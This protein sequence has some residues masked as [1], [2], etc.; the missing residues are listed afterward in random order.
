MQKNTKTYVLLALV[1]LI[2]GIVGYKLMNWGASEELMA[3]PIPVVDFKPKPQKE[4]DTFRIVAHYRDP[5]LG[6]A[7]NSETA[8]KIKK[9]KPKIEE[10]PMIAIVY[11]GSITDS[12]TKQKI[13]FVTV[14]GQQQIMKPKDSFSEVKLLSGSSEQIKVEYHHKQMTI[15]LQK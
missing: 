9:A 6:T 13:F 4:K 1:L 5:F 12:S 11:T 15:P 3:T 2:W 8:S 10:P 7:L 14:N